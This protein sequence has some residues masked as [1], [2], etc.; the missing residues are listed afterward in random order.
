MYFFNFYWPINNHN[1]IGKIQISGWQLRMS[2]SLTFVISEKSAKMQ[3]KTIGQPKSLVQMSYGRYFPARKP[4]FRLEAKPRAW[5][6]WAYPNVNNYYKICQEGLVIN[7]GTFL[8][9]LQYF[10]QFLV[11]NFQQLQLFEEFTPEGL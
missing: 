9:R 5:L 8:W 10:T 4:G 7:I 11:W 3:N 1:Q 2:K 6:V